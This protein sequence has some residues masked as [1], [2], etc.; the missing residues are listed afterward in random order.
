MIHICRIFLI[1]LATIYALLRIVALRFSIE[2][3][4]LQTCCGKNH[5]NFVTGGPIV[6]GVF[7]AVSGLNFDICVIFTQ[8]RTH[9]E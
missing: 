7:S 3:G 2:K 5:Y 4:Y 8:I 6:D 9:F 1:F